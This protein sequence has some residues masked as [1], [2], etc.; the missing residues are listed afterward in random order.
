MRIKIYNRNAQLTSTNPFRTDDRKT[1]DHSDEQPW[2]LGSTPHTGVADDADGESS[3]Q[4]CQA[5]RKTGTELDEAGVEWHRRSDCSL[6]SGGQ[7]CDDR[8]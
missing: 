3:G 8:G 7:N 5:D 1:T 6:Q 4:T 2:L